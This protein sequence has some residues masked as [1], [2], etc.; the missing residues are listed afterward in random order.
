[1][2]RIG[3]RPIPIPDGVEIR[4]D[5]QKVSVKEKENELHWTVVPE[6]EVLLE[7]GALHVR[8]PNPNKRTNSLWGTTRTVLDNLVT[9]VHQ[10]F[11]RVLELVGTGYRVALKGKTLTFE[12][13]FDHPVEYAVAADVEVTV[14]DR[15][16]KIT[17]KGIDRQRVGQVA[18][19]IRA[20]KRPEPYH[21][22]GIRYEGE[23]VRKKAGKAG[24]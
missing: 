3:K 2:S 6:L 16:P 17:V 15:P 14:S 20:L 24:A 23:Q 13:G 18:A 22:K 1:M 12:I 9:G 21:G 10:G 4:I 8:N 11:T 7:E 5:G 19:E